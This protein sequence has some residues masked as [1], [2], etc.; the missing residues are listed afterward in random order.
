MLIGQSLIE[1]EAAQPALVRFLPVTSRQVRRGP[2]SG[3]QETPPIE[4]PPQPEPPL[5]G[6]TPQTEPPPQPEP[7]LVGPT[8]QTEPPRTPGSVA[9]AV[10]FEVSHHGDFAHPP[11]NTDNL[12]TETSDTTLQDAFSIIKPMADAIVATLSNL[13]KTPQDAEVTFGLA[14]KAN[15]GAAIALTPADANVNFKLTW[16]F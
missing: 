5:V 10:H 2:S 6:P 4:P 7:P 13:N 8:P 16:A 15:S 12:P 1:K 11:D 14:M 3:S 9:S